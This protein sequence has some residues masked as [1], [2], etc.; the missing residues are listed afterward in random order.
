MR[1][2]KNSNSKRKKLQITMAKNNKLIKILFHFEFGISLK[3]A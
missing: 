1:N 2:I 3:P